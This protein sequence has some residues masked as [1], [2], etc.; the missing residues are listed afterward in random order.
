[1]YVSA[2]PLSPANIPLSRQFSARF[3]NTLRVAYGRDMNWPAV[4]TVLRGHTDSINSVSFLPDGTRIVTGSS[5]NTI[6]LWDAGTGE[7]VGERLRGHT[8]SINSVSF[9][10]DGTRI[11]T[12][13]WDK[14]VRLWDARTGEPVGESLWGHTDSVNSVSFSPDGTRIVTGL[15]N[16]TVR[17]WDAVMSQPSPYCAVSGPSA[18]SDE[19]RI[20]HPI[21][22]TT[23]MTLNTRNNHFICFSPNSIH[24]LC[25]TFEL[26]G[27]ASHDN[28]SSNPFVLN[29]NGWVVGPKYRLL[30]WVPPA[31]RDPF[32]N[33]ATVIVIPRGCP[34]LDLS[35]MAHGQH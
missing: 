2:L 33:P 8:D 27:G 4:Q 28:R 1:M 14:T 17:L 20:I 34:E 25:N 9:S 31:S 21:E 26:M 24:A 6:Q 11:V 15:H 19:H 29:G 23:P 7:P 16:K 35:R 10:P 18:L 12:G 22:S 32:Y 13:S 3:P 30:F 5:D